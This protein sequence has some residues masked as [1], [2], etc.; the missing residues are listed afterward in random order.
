MKKYTLSGLL[1]LL[2]THGIYAAEVSAAGRA[3]GGAGAPIPPVV[4]RFKEQ[5]DGYVRDEID[6][7]FA[8]IARADDLGEVIPLTLPQLHAGYKRDRK[9]VQDAWVQIHKPF[10]LNAKEAL[11]DALKTAAADDVP[12]L[13]QEL[14]QY[15]DTLTNKRDEALARVKVLYR[16]RGTAIR[17][18]LFKGERNKT[19][20]LPWREGVTSI[21]AQE[22]AN[23]GEEVV[24]LGTKLAPSMAIVGSAYHLGMPEETKKQMWAKV[25]ESG[26]SRGKELV[27]G[28]IAAIGLWRVG[29]IGYR[30]VQYNRG[31]ARVNA[32]WSPVAQDLDALVDFAAYNFDTDLRGTLGRAFADHA[33]RVALGASLRDN[34][35]AIR[36]LEVGVGG[37]NGQV[38]DLNTAFG[39]HDTRMNTGFAAQAARVDGLQK[40]LESIQVALAATDGKVGAVGVD[41]S[42]MKG[43]VAGIRT[44]IAA[45]N[46]R[47]RAHLELVQRALASM[48]AAHADFRDAVQAARSSSGSDAS[49]EASPRSSATARPAP[50]LLASSQ[51]PI[52]ASLLGLKPENLTPLAS[53]HGRGHSRRVPFG[54]CADTGRLPAAGAGDT[55]GTAL[56]IG[57]LA[58]VTVSASLGSRS[59]R[60]SEGGAASAAAAATSSLSHSAPG[61]LS[62]GAAA[63]TPLK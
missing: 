47:Q 17:D 58:A 10:L 14:L 39:A 45:M 53:G 32:S 11:T 26:T 42:S 13:Q 18:A 48:L 28:V 56:S 49:G 23:L 51:V 38:R 36:S 34:T 60:H 63:D 31:H 16:D 44:D 57:A 27:L 30:Q 37:L 54:S 19:G 15:T 5:L 29:S 25:L 6:S 4:T 52:L 22:A 59:P 33:E 9:A 8:V 20:A 21:V 46:D 41:V 61:R 43:D 40:L 7:R 62:G 35:A 24:G 3:H 50:A 1:V 55:R 2:I 12:L